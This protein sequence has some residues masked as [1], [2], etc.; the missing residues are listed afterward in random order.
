MSENIDI[1]HALG[2]VDWDGSGTIDLN[3]RLDAT[4]WNAVIFT[5]SA[6]QGISIVS[7][8]NSPFKIMWSVGGSATSFGG[9]IFPS[10]DDIY[11]VGRPLL[12]WSAGLFSR[13]VSVGSD[14][15]RSLVTDSLVS[16][17]ATGFQANAT[18]ILGNI[19]PTVDQARSLG[20]PTFRWQSITAR[21]GSFGGT[22]NSLLLTDDGGTTSALIESKGHMRFRVE[23]GLG[24]G[25]YIFGNQDDTKRLTVD[26]GFKE[27]FPESANTWDLGFSNAFRS[28]YLRGS[29]INSVSNITL[30]PTSAVVPDTDNSKDMG[31]AALRWRHGFFAGTLSA[32]SMAAG[33]PG[34]ALASGEIFAATV[35]SVG[36]S[37]FMSSSIVSAGAS[38]FQTNATSTLAALVA[39]GLL[40]TQSIIPDIN[41]TRNIGSATFGYSLIFS[42]ELRAPIGT[43]LILRTG[44][45]SIILKLLSIVPNSDNSLDLG[46]A[47]IRW[48]RGF[49]S[50][51]ISAATGFASG[52]I[53]RSVAAGALA[54]S[55][56]ASAGGGFQTNSNS[57]FGASILPLGDIAR[58]LGGTGLRWNNLWVAT[59]NA[60]GG[61]LTINA[62]VLQPNA[63]NTRDLGTSALRWRQ[64]LYAG[65]VS[66][67]GTLGYIVATGISVGT[68]G[69][70]GYSFV[71]QH[72]S[73]PPDQN[74]WL[75]SKSGDITIDGAVTPIAIQNPQNDLRF[76]TNIAPLTDNARALSLSTRRW[77]SL[78]LSASLLVSLSTDSAKRLN[79]NNNGDGNITAESAAF[80][81]ANLI[82]GA[83]NSGV[84]NNAVIL[85]SGSSSGAVGQT[86]LTV[87]PGDGTVRPGNTNNTFDL[88]A[89]ANDAG[90]IGNRMWRGIFFATQASFGG[91]TGQ[92]GFTTN[93]SVGLSFGGGS[94]A[95]AT[96]FV[97]GTRALPITVNGVTFYI[98][99]HPAVA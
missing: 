86:A 13:V 19:R 89:R 94:T 48:K 59:V 80:G 5:V 40:T 88:G 11:R 33:A 68:R 50:G 6:G 70:Q 82:L 38:G 51:T 64:G 35:V 14:T 8:G 77:T 16:A 27:I 74:L 44:S 75:F 57:T 69:T 95:A 43:D 60:D 92:P 7:V 52:N 4:A 99:L 3:E 36:A 78:H 42:S 15:V 12:R 97:A 66:T 47:A 37:S 61:T 9:D 23:D 20:S 63:D 96:T 98:Q 72:P 79:I 25:I 41:I 31:T 84:G 24:E 58:D 90:T 32:G 54:I 62:T 67:G 45:S 85:L 83:E 87:A 34:R 65:T 21:I 17:G 2:A 73:N 91:A 81:Q 22:G 93:T 18:S 39:N 49:F 56:Q 46:E 53:G 26:S 76:D 29:V 71:G 28:L 10:V 1:R 30:N 55:G